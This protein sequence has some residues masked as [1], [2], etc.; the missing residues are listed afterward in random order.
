MFPLRDLTAN[1]A[2][3]TQW[4][5][6]QTPQLPPLS[7]PS[8]QPQNSCSATESHFWES[9]SRKCDEPLTAP[10][11][12]C[13]ELPADAALSAFF[14]EPDRRDN[15]TPRSST[16]NLANRPTQKFRPA[17]GA[18]VLPSSRPNHFNYGDFLRFR[19]QPSGIPQAPVCVDPQLHDPLQ[20][21]PK[22]TRTTAYR[23][24][25]SKHNQVAHLPN[26]IE[27]GMDSDHLETNKIGNLDGPG[28]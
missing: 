6:E 27:R 23:N 15:I 9:P 20:N 10:S 5:V 12:L 24:R 3:N 19:R 22:P 16:H 7:A 13:L 1:P 17:P 18:E 8:E 2:R 28:D 25:C 11:T 14:D 4:A 21:F 26:R